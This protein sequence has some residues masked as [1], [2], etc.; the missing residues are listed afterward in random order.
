VRS[1][2]PN[3]NTVARLKSTILLPPP[4]FGLATPLFETNQFTAYTHNWDD[5]ALRSNRLKP[6]L[7]PGFVMDRRQNK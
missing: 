2:V 6:V 3:K 1:G 7:Q 4:N 5:V